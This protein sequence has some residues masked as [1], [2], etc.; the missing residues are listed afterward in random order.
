MM[1]R[2][3]KDK[4]RMKI[5]GRMGRRREEEEEEEEEA[6]ILYIS[7]A[8]LVQSNLRSVIASR[9]KTRRT[10]IITKDVIISLK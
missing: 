9:Q 8:R 4:R 7:K 3:C 2:R 1:E 5:K 6:L 10:V